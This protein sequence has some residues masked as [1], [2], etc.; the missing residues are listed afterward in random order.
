MEGDPPI[1]KATD[2]VSHDLILRLI[3][4]VRSVSKVLLNVSNTDL[5][6]W[7]EDDDGGV[8]KQIHRLLTQFCM[9]NEPMVLFIT[10]EAEDP[11]SDQDKGVYNQCFPR[12]SPVFAN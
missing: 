7:L 6:V 8:K 11:I 2:L 4:Y 5:D 10:S 9:E 12:T 1:E 3:D